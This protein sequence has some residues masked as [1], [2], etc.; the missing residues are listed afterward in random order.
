MSLQSLTT[1]RVGGL[2]E[3]LAMPRHLSEFEAVLAWAI[4][5]N[6]TITPLGAGS[7][8]LISD[9]GISGLVLCT[10]R[11]RS[12][13]FDDTGRV[14]VAAG[15]PLPTLAWKAAKRGCRGLEWAVGIPGTVG[16]AVVMNAGAHGGCAADVLTSAT[17][18]DPGLG[19]EP[20]LVQLTPAELAFQY[21]T[22]ALQGGQRVVLEAT[23]QLE[24]GYDPAVV[25]ADTLAGLNQ[26]RATQPYDMPNCGSVFRNPYPHTAGTLI[27]QAGLKGYRIGNAQVAERHA[28]FILNLGGA[29]ATDIRRLI[30]HVQDRVEDRW[31]VRLQPEVKFM[32]EFPTP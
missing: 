12:T 31:A 5:A 27:E 13:E 4:A 24:P 19:L 17:V 11:W 16:G 23:F 21:R 3:W 14:T 7:N 32:G 2:A 1:F 10:R 29:T 8:L 6:L 22:S 20:K 30:H 26:R 15:E 25:M 9:R 18:L 28:N